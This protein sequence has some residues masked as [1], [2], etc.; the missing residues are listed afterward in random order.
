MS[1]YFNYKIGIKDISIACIQFISIL[2][3]DSVLIYID[4]PMS[5]YPIIR[6]TSKLRFLAIIGDFRNPP[7]VSVDRDEIIFREELKIIVYNIHTES[8]TSYDLSDI[9]STLFYTV[10]RQYIIFHAAVGFNIYP[11]SMDREKCFNLTIKSQYPEYH[12]TEKISYA[13][14][15]RK[16]IKLLPTIRILQNIHRFYAE[17]LVRDL[18]S[19][20]IGFLFE[21]SE[22]DPE[23]QKLALFLRDYTSRGCKLE[24]D[25]FQFRKRLMIELY[26]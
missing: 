14:L 13:F 3:D 22:V 2:T 11:R 8:R 26:S 4:L 25:K 9:E 7:M 17:Y 19:L 23:I 12:L 1:K 10:T 5:N 18:L 21:I 24:L 20:I 15:V 6:L 16:A